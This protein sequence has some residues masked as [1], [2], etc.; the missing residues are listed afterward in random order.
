MNDDEVMGRIRGLIELH[1]GICLGPKKDLMLCHRLERRM[2]ASGSLSLKDYYF[3]LVGTD[4]GELSNL[5]DEITVNET[6]LFRD[7]P[8]LQGFAEKVLPPYLDAKRLKRDYRLRL[9]SAA[10]S[11]GEE[12]YTLSIILR[13]MIRD[14]PMWDVRIEATDIDRGA[15]AACREGVF[16]DRSMKDTPVPYRIRYFSQTESGWRVDPMLT[17]AIT[18]ERAN[19]MD[20]GDMRLRRDYDF[21]FCRNVLIYFNEDSQR[22]VVN[23]FYDALVA[24]GYLFLGHSESVGRLTAA[25][26]LERMDRFLAYRK[27][28]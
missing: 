6:Y 28:L 2:A 10:C 7:F 19:L 15:L 12:P 25:F 16:S 27:P 21:I 24:G 13:E 9:W 26:S 23:G 22:K 1:T 3:R 14:Y 11:T 18:F 17:C 20:R 4:R 5:I 8:Q